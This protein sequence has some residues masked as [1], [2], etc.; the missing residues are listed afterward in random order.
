[1]KTI[2]S[3]L[4]GFFLLIASSYA[5]A[6]E[7]EECFS[8]YNSLRINYDDVTSAETLYQEILRLITEINSF[9][10]QSETAQ[11]MIPYDRYEPAM[12]RELRNIV[13]RENA[14]VMKVSC[15]V[16]GDQNGIKVA[17]IFEP[18]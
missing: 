8:V 13:Q 10:K 6:E 11:V 1:M 12:W 2:L 7:V 4:V 18:K 3:I 15:Y 16:M 17:C 5:Y 9:A 14:L